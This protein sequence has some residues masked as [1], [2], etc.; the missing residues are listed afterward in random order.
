MSDLGSNIAFQIES[1]SD[2]ALRDVERK[3]SQE[4]TTS[5]RYY[6]HRSPHIHPADVCRSLSG[7]HQF[8]VRDVLYNSIIRRKITLEHAEGLI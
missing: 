5:R 6:L 7:L 8:D 1:F 3:N 2:L 4:M